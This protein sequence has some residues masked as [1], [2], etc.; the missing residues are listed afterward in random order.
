MFGRGL[1][2]LAAVAAILVVGSS[3]ASGQQN[4]VLDPESVEPIV[5]WSVGE[6]LA[7]RGEDVED[8]SRRHPWVPND[9]PLPLN[10]TYVEGSWNNP[11]GSLTVI[12]CLLVSPPNIPT[13]SSR[14]CSGRGRPVARAATSALTKLPAER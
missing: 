1:A 7:A 2:L 11:D 6:Q 8:L 12:Y 4:P 5:P 3:V 9:A 14:T 10:Y 13:G